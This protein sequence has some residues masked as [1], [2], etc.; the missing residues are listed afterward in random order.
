M[1]VKRSDHGTVLLGCGCVGRCSILAVDRWK[2]EDDAE[3]WFDI[4][5]RPGLNVSRGWRWRQALK[6]IFGREVF[7][8]SLCV[9]EDEIG[10]L[11]DLLNAY[12]PLLTISNTQTQWTSNG[13]DIEETTA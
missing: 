12:P 1:T 6:L 9:T 5:T 8:E 10:P 3:W 4:Y 13:P 11:R 7:F 2:F